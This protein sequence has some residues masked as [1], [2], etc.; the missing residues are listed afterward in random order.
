MKPVAEAQPREAA[1]GVRGRGVY[2]APA[3]A[4][5]PGVVDPRLTREAPRPARDLPASS[6]DPSGALGGAPVEVPGKTGSRRG[7]RALR[8][9]EAR[10][11]SSYP[12]FIQG[13]GSPDARW[14]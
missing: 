9:S 5:V 12:L 14:Q 1:G 7:S 10:L 8:R 4:G 11:Y 6:S 13:Q 3:S 2:P